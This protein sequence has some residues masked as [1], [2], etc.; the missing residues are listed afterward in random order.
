[1]NTVGS[2]SLSFLD[3]SSALANYS[4]DDNGDHQTN[5]RLTHVYGHG[6]DKSSPISEMDISGSWYDPSHDGEGFIIEQ[7]SAERAVVFWFTYDE[8]GKQSWLFNTGSIDNGTIHVPGLMQ[9]SGGH[10]GRSFDPGNVNKT[11]WG[12]LTLDL[13]CSGGI[14]SY[15]PQVEGYSSGSQSL[16]PLTRLAGSSCTD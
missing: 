7:V 4:V 13:D 12:E 3:C 2:L 5:S 6:C 1:M 14:A 15:T 9:P 10:F 11:E 8:T 16:V